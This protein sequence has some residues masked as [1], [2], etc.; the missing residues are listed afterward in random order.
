[1]IVCYT[2]HPNLLKNELSHLQKVLRTKYTCE[3][4]HFTA[5]RTDKPTS[6]YRREDLLPLLE[7]IIEV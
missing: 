4:L 3:T 7:E 6:L 5:E 1:M 2:G